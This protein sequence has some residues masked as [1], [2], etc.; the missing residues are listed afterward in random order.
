MDLPP[1]YR[2]RLDNSHKDPIVWETTHEFI[3]G[4]GYD[5]RSGYAEDK[6]YPPI[7]PS[8]MRIEFS[9]KINEG[10]AVKNIH[11]ELFRAPAMR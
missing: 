8:H 3:A 11:S 9:G 6:L 1:A 5:S 10:K 2:V 4:S 7:I